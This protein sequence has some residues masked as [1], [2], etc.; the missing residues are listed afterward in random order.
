MTE[1]GKIQFQNNARQTA[2]QNGTLEWRSPSNIALTKYWGKHEGQIPMNPSLSMTLKY[3]FTQTEVSWEPKNTNEEVAFDFFL[4]HEKAGY[5]FEKRIEKL[6]RHFAKEFPHLLDYRFNIKSINTFPHSTGIASSAS[7]LSA[8]A[9]SL[10]S[11]ALKTTGNSMNYTEQ[12]RK[13]SYYARMG[14]GSACRSVEGPYMIWG[15]GALDNSSDEFAVPFVPHQDFHKIHDT[16]ILFDKRPKKVGSSA[17]HALMREH[18]YRKGR[19]AQAGKNTKKLIE[20]MNAGDFETWQFITEQEA[21]SLHAL[22][23]SSPQPVLL[24]EPNTLKF[25][26]D[27]YEF[28]TGRGYKVAFTIDAGP[29]VHLLYA[30]SDREVIQGFIGNWLLDNHLQLEVIDDETGNGAKQLF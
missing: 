30:P 8:L 7:G 19:I 14:S 25:I 11:V 20:A 24:L 29:N 28:R 15:K 3:A 27:L 16:I 12:I 23:M 5:E 18:P 26:H 21:L 2:Q 22:M 4:G 10:L 9:L 17:G 1:F 6:I 13:A